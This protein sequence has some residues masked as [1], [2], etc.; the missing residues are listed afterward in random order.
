MASA[1]NLTAKIKQDPE[2]LRKLEALKAAFADKVQPE[3]DKALRKSKMVHFARV[4][5]IDDLYIQVLTEFDGDRQTYTEFF[6]QELP[7]V[8]KAIFELVDGAPPWDQLNNPDTFFKLAQHKHIKSLGKDSK[9]DSTGDT[10]GYL[11][12]IYGNAQ[13]KEIL[14][15]KDVLVKI[16]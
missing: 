13:V 12:S 1:L 14:A 2:T 4:L 16:G 15:A 10:Q 7:N 5:V 8:F 6:R 3:I 9:S 11:F